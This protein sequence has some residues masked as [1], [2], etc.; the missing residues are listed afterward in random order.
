MTGMA[1][2]PSRGECGK[3]ESRMIHMAKALQMTL[4]QLR[5][6]AEEDEREEEEESSAEYVECNPIGAAAI[7]QGVRVTQRE[8]RKIQ[9][10]ILCDTGAGATVANGEL[11]F[12]EFPLE[13]SAG[14]RQGQTFVGPGHDSIQNR[15]QRKVQLRLG[16]E[17]GRAAGFRFQDA[18]VR[19]PILSVGESTDMNNS[20]WFDKTGS[21]ILPSGCKEIA[22]IRKII[23][24]VKDKLEMKKEKNVFTM[25]AW[26]DASA[27][28]GFTR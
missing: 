28:K 24:S 14:S 9:Q 2:E 6:Q 8:G 18:N 15:G 22:Q 5:S 7:G 10:G 11:V 20:F 13:E 3:E 27:T 26:V 12:P 4:R 23:Q 1:E 21:F 16:S 17:N 19:R 25:D